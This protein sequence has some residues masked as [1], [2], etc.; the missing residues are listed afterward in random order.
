MFRQK[1]TPAEIAGT[2]I[3]PSAAARELRE[4]TELAAHVGARVMLT[5]EYGVGKRRVGRLIHRHS[6]RCHGPFITVRCD[7]G[8]AQADHLERRIFGERGIVRGALTR[9]DGGT[10]FFQDLEMLSARLQDRLMEF[11][12]TGEVKPIGVN[13]GGTANVRLLTATTTK[14]IEKVESGDFRSDLYYLLNP[15]L[16]QIAPLRERSEDIEPLLEYFTRYYARRHGLGS[17]RLSVESRLAC[18]LYPWPGNLRQL[19]AA[20]AMFAS[21][22]SCSDAEDLTG[23]FLRPTEQE[24]PTPA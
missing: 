1:H 24:Y 15:M 21:S 6:I 9:A 5:G 13:A 16:I 7:H 11:L 4:E 3:G 20:A 18:R 2:L 12:V 23:R 19:Q 17:P 14:L 10:V 22:P 8:Q